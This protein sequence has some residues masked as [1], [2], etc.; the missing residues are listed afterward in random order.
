RCA[1]AILAHTQ[2]KRGARRQANAPEADTS[3]SSKRER[4]ARPSWPSQASLEGGSRECLQG[5]QQANAGRATDT[6]RQAAHGAAAATETEEN[7]LG[8][9]QRE[10][11]SAEADEQRA[12]SRDGT[13]GEEQRTACGAPGRPRRTTT[14]R[15]CP[16]LWSEAGNER[17]IK[18]MAHTRTHPLI[19]FL[20]RGVA[21]SACRKRT[22]C[23][24]H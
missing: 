10:S 16:W 4:A 11:G 14:A 12:D 18:M 22:G 13:K 8:K 1:G 9:A 17:S 15:S 24:V 19:L 5:C 3:I 6:R 20:P 23:D 21:R 7:D 2:G